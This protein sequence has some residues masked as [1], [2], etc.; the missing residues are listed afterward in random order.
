[1]VQLFLGGGK[2]LTRPIKDWAPTAAEILAIEA[3]AA[4][5][6]VAALARAID[7][8]WADLL[9]P[10]GG[11]PDGVRRSARAIAAEY[12]RLTETDHAPD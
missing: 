11:L 5:L 12:A 10:L 4:Q 8:N 9:A 6:D 1:M 7:A 2:P 3:E